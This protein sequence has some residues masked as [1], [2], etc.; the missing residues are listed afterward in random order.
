VLRKGSRSF[1]IDKDGSSKVLQSISEVDGLGVST[2]KVGSRIL[3]LNKRSRKQSLNG[4]S[5]LCSDILNEII[6]KMNEK[7][8]E[9][10]EY[11][12][13]NAERIKVPLN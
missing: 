9:R 13:L 10:T 4:S 8:D 1:G 6:S 3:D 11:I 2:C 5:G 12:L 7:I